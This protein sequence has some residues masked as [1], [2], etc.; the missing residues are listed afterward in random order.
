[1]HKY[2]SK[3]IDWAKSPYRDDRDETNWEQFMHQLRIEANTGWRKTIMRSQVSRGMSNNFWPMLSRLAIMDTPY[4]AKYIH[5]R[6]VNDLDC[7]QGTTELIEAYM[8]ITGHLPQCSDWQK[9]KE[10]AK[11]SA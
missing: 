5:P 2:W 4:L 8:L 10:H 9:A 3:A 1:M 11:E 7:T 6:R